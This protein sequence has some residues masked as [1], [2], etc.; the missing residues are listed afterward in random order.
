M[1]QELDQLDANY[2]ARRAEVQAANAS[3]L[4]GCSGQSSRFSN[5]FYVNSCLYACNLA[6]GTAFKDAQAELYLGYEA[7]EAVIGIHQQI[8]HANCWSLFPCAVP[9]SSGGDPYYN[10]WRHRYR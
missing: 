7:S 4:S 5:Q 3:C 1:G 2:A 10:S 8:E 6:C 9:E